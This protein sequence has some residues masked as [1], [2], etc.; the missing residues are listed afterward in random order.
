MLKQGVYEHI[1]NRETE[2][3]IEDSEQAGLVCSTQPMDDAEAPQILA[4]YIAKVIRQKLE[5][6]ETQQERI[7]MINRIMMDAGL[8]EFKEIVKPTDLLAEVM[9]RQQHAMQTES[10][11]HIVRPI[12]GFRSSN[13]FTGGNR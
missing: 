13:L 1:I 6:I 8:S 3:D 9:S 7:D 4:D 2:N 12:S 11:S 5:D 10:D